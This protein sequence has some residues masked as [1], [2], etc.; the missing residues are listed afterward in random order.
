MVL[1][2]LLVGLGDRNGVRSGAKKA[3]E[4][5]SASAKAARG[6]AHKREQM[7]KFLQDMFAPVS[8]SGRRSATRR[9]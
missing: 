1:G 2:A 5:V 9:S 8:T 3:R 4:A 7:A 6:E